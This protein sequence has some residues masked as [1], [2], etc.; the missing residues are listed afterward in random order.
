MASRDEHPAASSPRNELTRGRTQ[1]ASLQLLVYRQE[2]CWAQAAGRAPSLLWN[3]VQGSKLLLLQS[4]LLAGMVAHL[5]PPPRG[6][7]LLPLDF[8]WWG[9]VPPWCMESTGPAS[10]SMAKWSSERLTPA[11]REPSWEP[12]IHSHC[13]VHGSGGD[14]SQSSSCSLSWQTYN[15][16][17]ADASCSWV[18]FFWS[19]DALFF[20]NGWK[21]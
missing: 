3:H 17:L 19:Q 1:K 16:Y 2:A 15:F 21:F 10:G 12:S 5:T 13:L 8:L 9:R 6:W 14:G 7:R 18:C 4:P 11:V 20:H